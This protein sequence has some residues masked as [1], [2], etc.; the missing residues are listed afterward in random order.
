MQVPN[1][2]HIAPLLNC[3][4]EHSNL[5][6]YGLHLEV[7]SKTV[8]E[9]MARDLLAT[10]AKQVG[11]TAFQ[12]RQED[13]LLPSQSLISTNWLSAETTSP[14]PSQTL[15]LKNQPSE[16]FQAPPLLILSCGV[17]SSWIDF[18]ANEL[19]SVPRWV[20]KQ[21]FTF[22]N[23]LITC[24][25]EKHSHRPVALA[26]EFDRCFF[27]DRVWLDK[28]AMG[29]RPLSS[30]RYASPGFY[31][32]ETIFSKCIFY[33]V[34]VPPCVGFIFNDCI[35]IECSFPDEIRESP[36]LTAEFTRSVFL[37]CSFLDSNFRGVSFSDVVMLKADFTSSVRFL[38]CRFK[39]TEI[40]RLDFSAIH[41]AGGLST[42]E[43]KQLDL[44]H[45]LESLRKQFG[46]FLALVHGVLVLAFCSP[47]VAFICGRLLAHNAATLQ[48]LSGIAA[49]AVVSRSPLITQ[50]L[51]YGLSGGKTNAALTIDWI[52]TISI[53]FFVF[54]N[55]VRVYLLFLTK[56]LEHEEFVSG[57]PSD[58]SFYNRPGI[59][60]VFSLSQHLFYISIV[61]SVWNLWVFFRREVPL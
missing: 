14:S 28:T 38:R 18:H 25:E 15:L 57:M 60:A 42:R 1:H 11:N 32:H 4:I 48:A 23:C 56:K 35:F 27:C 31:F 40:S 41:E 19:Q 26:T 5:P 58:F 13:D 7:V 20:R 61:A 44:K 43:L 37:A 22:R 49:D 54:Y 50:L 8:I 55:S 33:R 17:D 6:F 39:K 59:F 47:Y 21:R 45:D 24:T 12:L 10:L 36:P 3:P 29:D 34:A 51:F 30:D 53:A 9:L 46:G 16:L 2:F 52:S